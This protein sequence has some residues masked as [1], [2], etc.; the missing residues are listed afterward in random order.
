MKTKEFIKMLQ[1]ED[2]TG[3]GNLR[4]YGGVPKFVERK[5]GYWDGPYE[6]LDE[7]GNFV[8]SI[9]GYKIDIHCVNLEDY[10]SGLADRND[11][12]KW[13]EVENKFKFELY[14]YINTDQRNEKIKGYLERARSSWEE[15]KGINNSSY[16]RSLDAMRKNAKDGWTWFQNKL[17]DSVGGSHHYYTW[18]IYSENGDERGSNLWNTEA[19]VKS[20]EWTKNDNGVKEGYYQWIKKEQDKIET[21]KSIIDKIKKLWKTR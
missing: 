9:A 8:T 13:E 20:G 10:A 12:Q 2:P 1:K 11:S 3:E 16:Q 6:Y 17:V 18:K 5:P 4:M 19:I 14:D 21:K 7:E 15:T